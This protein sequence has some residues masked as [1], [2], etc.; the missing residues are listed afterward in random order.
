MFSSMMSRV[1]GAAGRTLFSARAL[2]TT[3]LRKTTQLK[4]MIQGKDLAF[5][6]EAHNGLSARIVEEEGFNV[7]IL[8]ASCTPLSLS[9]SLHCLR[10]AA[11]PLGSTQTFVRRV[12]KR[13]TRAAPCSA[14][15][16]QQ[17]Y[18]VIETISCAS[19]D[20]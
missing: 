6:M 18:P 11:T 4:N 16:Q 2:S 13:R 5:I 8:Y 9:L 10:T 7:R 17:R 12:D 19:N 3:P 15:Q 1:S 14:L 20:V